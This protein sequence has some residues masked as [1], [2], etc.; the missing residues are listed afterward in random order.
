MWRARWRSFKSPDRVFAW[1]TIRFG[2][3]PRQAGRHRIPPTDTAL[4][5]S[6]HEPHHDNIIDTTLDQCV[7]RPFPQGTPLQFE[8]L[9][10]TAKT[11]SV[12]RGDH[13]S[14]DTH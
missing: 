5:T 8:V 14:P 7:A 13:D 12:P 4:D 3:N 2:R 9:F 1:P 6:R 11:P 10:G